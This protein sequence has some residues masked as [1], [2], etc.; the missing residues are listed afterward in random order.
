MLFGCRP[1]GEGQSQEK[2]LHENTMLRATHVSFPPK[3][4]VSADAKEFIRACL[5]H[6][7]ADRPD[8][9]KLC[10][11]PYLRLKKL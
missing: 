9:L 2:V 8:V 11:H 10:Q 7:Q 6:S 3:P 4:P 1:F 5:T